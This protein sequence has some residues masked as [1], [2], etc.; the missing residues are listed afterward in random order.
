MAAVTTAVVVGA[1]TVFVAGVVAGRVSQRLQD[2]TRSQGWEA[3]MA[4]GYVAGEILKGAA[5]VVVA[6]LPISK[7]LKQKLAATPLPFWHFDK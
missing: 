6:P 4:T 7:T 2:R 3:T 5:R 1:G